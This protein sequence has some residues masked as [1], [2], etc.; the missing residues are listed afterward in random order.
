MATIAEL[1]VRASVDNRDLERKFAASTRRAQAFAD[2]LGNIGTRLTL[3][4]TLPLAAAGAGIFT[5]AARMESLN[6][7]LRRVA[8]SSQAAAQQLSRL[9]QIARAPGIGFQEA[10]A[11]SVRLQSVGF[12]AAFAERNLREFANAIALTGGGREELSRVITQLSQLSSKGKVLTQDLRPIIEA[13]PAVGQAL[14]KAFGTVNAETISNLG[15]STEEFLTR[16]LDAMGEMPRA[17]GGLANAFENLKDSIFVAFAGVGEGQVSPLTKLIDGLA[18]RV[19]VLSRAFAALPASTQQAVFILGG[20]VA[21]AGPLALGFS[22]FAR[23][24]V[25]VRAVTIGLTAAVTALK[26]GAALSGLASLVTPGGVLLVGLGLLASMFVA[27]KLEALEFAKIMRQNADAYVEQVR[28][29][30]DAEAQ[31]ALSAKALQIARLNATKAFLQNRLLEAQLSEADEGGGLRSAISRL[32]VTGL[33]Q[34]P[35]PVTLGLSPTAAQRDV[36]RIQALL[37]TLG[38]SITNAMGE[39]STLSGE[40]RGR[41]GDTANNFGSVADEAAKTGNSLSQVNE[42]LREFA[43]ASRI[44]LA[45]LTD[46]PETL[47]DAFQVAEELR[48]RMESLTTSLN[49]MGQRAPSG[50]FALLNALQTALAQAEGTVNRI[51]ERLQNALRDGIAVDARIQISNRTPTNVGIDRGTGS[52][53]GGDLSPELSRTQAALSAL[54]EVGFQAAQGMRAFG[55]TVQDFGRS[56]LQ[57]AVSGLAGLVAQL[58]PA[59]LAAQAF[60]TVVDALRPVVEALL[61]PVS[62]VAQVFAAGLIPILKLLFPVIKAVGIVFTYLQEITYRVI[63]AVVGGFGFLLRALGAFINAITPFSNPGNPLI[64]AGRF[65]EQTASGF[66]DAARE[67]A[68]ARDELRNLSWEDALARGTAAMDRLTQSV[69]N[70]SEG[71]KIERLRFN[72]TDASASL[73]PPTSPRTSSAGSVTNI[74]GNVTVEISGRDLEHLSLEELGER[75]VLALQLRQRFRPQSAPVVGLL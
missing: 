49:E 70:A 34:G 27:A 5:A 12:S 24:L 47:R 29:M 60:A 61:V 67:A 55:A 17:T 4:L 58:T 23:I 53:F 11:G 44:G 20:M 69:V 30:S 38:T 66:L 73:L 19:G 54:A 6:L 57:N 63:G 13:G 31:A 65:M 72:A 68:R 62:I 42:Q 41:L 64:R 35:A 43:V 21:L 2:T 15:L 3:G 25:T 10:I 56:Q 52:L 45:T 36:G 7:G 14:L 33:F 18:D 37:D 1:I 75:V 26:S 46:A 8:G 16:L 32:R 39:L 51:A 74:N 59:G 22:A 9:T 28:R 50:G 48:G 71:F 40:V